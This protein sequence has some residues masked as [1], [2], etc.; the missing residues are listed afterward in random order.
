MIICHFA[1]PPL[2]FAIQI[3][4]DSIVI[5]FLLFI[6]PLLLSAR[7]P[8]GAVFLPMH[9]LA[10]ACKYVK[11]FFEKNQKNFFGVKNDAQ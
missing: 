3:C 8:A 7:Y 1:F 11:P 9:I 4:V 5:S 10:H 6:F 2:V